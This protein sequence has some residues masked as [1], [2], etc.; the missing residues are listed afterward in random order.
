LGSAGSTE[1]EAAVELEAAGRAIGLA[2]ASGSHGDTVERDRY[3]TAL[4]VGTPL[5]RAGPGHDKGDLVRTTCDAAFPAERVTLLAP[6][7]EFLPEPVIE[8]I[9]A[10]PLLMSSEALPEYL[11]ENVTFFVFPGAAE[12][13]GPADSPTHISATS[14]TLGMCFFIVFLSVGGSPIL[15][16]RIVSHF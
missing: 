11:L 8:E 9:V 6:N 10:L 1:L 3:W 5:L 16:E 15:T 13:A 4:T 14:T 7:N 2:V 12:N